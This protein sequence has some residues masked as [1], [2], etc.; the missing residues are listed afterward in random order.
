[1]SRKSFD[2]RLLAVLSEP[3]ELD[4]LIKA[5]KAIGEK[6][7][8]MTMNGIMPEIE[9]EGKKY[10]EVVVK[11]GCIGCAFEKMNCDIMDRPYCS[12]NFREDHKYIIFKEAKS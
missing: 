1:M 2:E 10:Y 9:I 8:E 7:E 5:H 3:A 6:I 11:G 4:E 12:S